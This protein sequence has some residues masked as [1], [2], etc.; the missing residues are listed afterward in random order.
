MFGV[1]VATGNPREA[2]AVAS[3]PPTGATPPPIIT[4]GVEVQPAPP[5]VTV[6]AVTF[7]PLTVAVA[8]GVVA[9]P[10]PKVIAG[11]EV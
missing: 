8:C 7:L 1:M 6:M 2:V 11:T 10:G 9:Q 4:V 3:V 5:F